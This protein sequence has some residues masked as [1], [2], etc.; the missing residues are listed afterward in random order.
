MVFKYFLSKSV[1]LKSLTLLLLLLKR[2][3]FGFYAQI[4][5]SIDILSL[6]LH[7]VLDK[8]SVQIL[9]LNTKYLN[10]TKSLNTLDPPRE[11]DLSTQ[12]QVYRYVTWVLTNHSPYAL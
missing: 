7:L 5:K 3:L 1:V 4:L 10:I 12:F 8:E 2:G 6:V 9:Y 11:E